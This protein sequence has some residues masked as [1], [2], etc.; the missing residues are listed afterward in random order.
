VTSSLGRAENSSSVSAVE[1][2]GTDCTITS[3]HSHSNLNS[4]LPED[5]EVQSQSLNDA[6]VEVELADLSRGSPVSLQ[7]LPEDAHVNSSKSD[8]LS[9]SGSIPNVLICPAPECLPAIFQ[10]SL[11]L[12]GTTPLVYLPDA[13]NSAIQEDK[14]RALQMVLQQHQCYDDEAGMNMRKKIISELDTLVKQWTR[15]EGLGRKM[16]WSH[17]EQVGGKVVSYGSYKLSVVDKESDLDL[18]CVVPKHI[19][20]D[21]FF[22]SLYEQLLKKEEVTELRQLPNAFVPVIKMKYRGVEVDLTLARVVCYDRIPEDEDFLLSS[23]ITHEMDPRC[24]R[25]LNGYR[26]TCEILQ[27]VPNVDKFR[28]TLRVVKLWAKKNGLY[29]NML[30]FLGGASWAIL[31][32]KVCQMAVPDNSSVTC[33]NLIYQ[34]FYTFANWD[35]P[36]P[37]FIKK[38][39][40]QPYSAWNPHMNPRD[41]EHVMPI[42]TSSVPQMNS[43]VN[44]SRENCQLIRQKCAEALPIVQGII[45]GSR[46]WPDLF[47]PSNFFEE[48]SNYVMVVSSALGDAALWFGSVEAKLRQLNQHILTE[49]HNKVVSAR[50]WPQPFDKQEGNVQ[51]QMW[52]FGIRM[53][54]GQSPENIQNPLIYFSD[55]CVRDI[56][57][58]NSRY[59]NSFLVDWRHLTRAELSNHL[60]KLQL[61]MGR[62]EKLSYAA[63]TVGQSQANTMTSSMVQTSIPQSTISSSGYLSN[64]L[65]PSS[66]ATSQGDYRHVTQPPHYNRVFPPPMSSVLPHPHPQIVYTYSLNPPQQGHGQHGHVVADGQYH[67]GAVPQTGGNTTSAVQKAVPMRPQS[68]FITMPL[69]RSHNSPQ[70]GGY[71]GQ[72]RSSQM[73]SM[74]RTRHGGNVKSSPQTPSSM[75]T[76][77]QQS[78]NSPGYVSNRGTG[79]MSGPPNASFPHPIPQLTN[80]PPPPISP[81]SQFNS[82]PPLHLNLLQQTFPPPLQRAESSNSTKEASHLRVPTK[83][84]HDQEILSDDSRLRSVS[85]SSDHIPPGKLNLNHARVTHQDQLPVSPSYCSTGVTGVVP[86]PNVDTSVPPPAMPT[87]LPP[88]SPPPLTF[89]SAKNKSLKIGR[90]P[91]ISQSEISDMSTPQPVRGCGVTSNSRIKVTWQSRRDHDEVFKF[92]Y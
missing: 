57:K 47:Q 24:L 61:S 75:M 52:F 10:H 77:T 44:M 76:S 40:N 22:I 30:G 19:S 51:K 2:N 36:K 28:L 87:P 90:S 91:R 26:A 68:N 7:E 39:E 20:R 59:M 55:L 73:E 6:M 18:L 86:L 1:T 62:S 67:S 17:V 45:D 69:N 81:M 8:I 92:N 34:F 29:G 71:P 16:P 42:I 66:Q 50:I 27:L 13:E 63:V 15:S 23:T 65:S 14:Y 60:S 3:E 79:L 12:S 72:G 38:V 11:I 9:R 33:T 21:N 46:S 85:N 80:Y 54:V 4:P 49:S 41:Q 84:R 64:V 74:L 78:Q 56:S 58:T 32:A 53:V 5:A 88:R 48:Y 70:P 25:S 35:W 83:S 31:V 43:A 82:P 37:V 89:N